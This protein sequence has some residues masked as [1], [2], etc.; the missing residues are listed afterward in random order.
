MVSHRVSTSVS[1]TSF[2]CKTEHA[3]CLELAPTAFHLCLRSQGLCKGSIG[4][5]GVTRPPCTLV[6][7]GAQVGGLPH[8]HAGEYVRRRDS[9]KRSEDA[10]AKKRGALGRPHSSY[11]RGTSRAVT[12][13]FG[14]IAVIS[15][16]PTRSHVFTNEQVIHARGNI[17]NYSET[18]SCPGCCSDVYLGRSGSLMFVLGGNKLIFTS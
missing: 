4:S 12:G 18:Q 11:P 10:V 1:Q 15:L 14:V 8:S 16:K 13:L 2:L 9:S 6:R 7:G 17:A 5:A 3:H